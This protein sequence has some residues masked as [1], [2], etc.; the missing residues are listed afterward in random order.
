M[1]EL[2]LFQYE[3]VAMVTGSVEEVKSL[4]Q[5][6]DVRTDFVDDVCI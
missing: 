2:I 1:V 4:L 5:D 6:P 3:S